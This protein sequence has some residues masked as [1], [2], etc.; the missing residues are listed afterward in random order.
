MTGVEL[1]VWARLR[2]RQL[3]GFK[4]RRQ[5]S[6]GP[7]IA[8]FACLSERLIVEVDGP[9]HDFTQ[10][11]DKSRTAWFRRHGYREFRVPADEVLRD[12]D[13]VLDGLALML[14]PL[15]RLSGGTSP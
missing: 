13:A 3:L 5:A 15:P 12:L 7:Y 2:R 14:L 11:H 10:M 4:F 6:I 1:M 9:T 8:D